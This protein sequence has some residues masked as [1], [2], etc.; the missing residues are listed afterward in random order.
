MS[1]Q[2]DLAAFLILCPATGTSLAANKGRLTRCVAAA[3]P[4]LTTVGAPATT[5]GVIS[6]GAYETP[7]MQTAEYALLENVPAGPYTWSSR[8]PTFDG[9]SV[10]IYAPG[11]AVTG[12]NKYN[13]QLTQLANGTS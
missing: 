13:L 8:G 4:A 5:S 7:S 9:E 12:V 2:S 6:V 10:S 1:E 3:G 11:A